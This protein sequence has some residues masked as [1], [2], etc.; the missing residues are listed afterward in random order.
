MPQGFLESILINAQE[1]VVPGRPLPTGFDE[2]VLADTE[3]TFEE[4][5]RAEFLRRP[6]SGNIF[7]TRAEFIAH[8]VERGL[9]TCWADNPCW[10]CANP[11]EAL[12][13]QGRAT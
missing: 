7:A 2:W 1:P 13:R 11:E 9:H 4:W 6:P 10:A 3:L 8:C 5:Q 12:K